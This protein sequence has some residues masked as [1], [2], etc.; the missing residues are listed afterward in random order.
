MAFTTVT[1]SNGVTSLVGTTGVDTA[2]LVTLESNTFVGANT[3]D[4]SITVTLGTGASRVSDY[5]VRLG[6]GD[7]T[8]GFGAATTVLNSFI[9]LDGETLANDGNDTYTGNGLI[10]NS[11]IVGRGGNDTFTGLQLSGSAVNGNTGDD[12]I[13]VGASSTSSVYGGQGLDVINVT[14]N[15]A[16]MMIN[17]NKGRDQISL[18]AVGAAITF[19][20][21]VYG[22]NGNDTITSTNV[23]VAAATSTGVFFSGDLGDDNITGTGGVD[24]INGGDGAD[25]LGGGAGADTISGGAGDDTITAGA[26]ADTVSGGAGND[27]FAIGATDSILAA[28]ASTGFD[29]ITDFSANTAAAGAAVNGDTLDLAALGGGGYALGGANGSIYT[30][31]AANLDADLTAAEA[32]G[33]LGALANA[34]D[35]SAVIIRGS[36]WAGN[37]I[38]QGDAT[39]G[40]DAG[41]TVIKVSSLNGVQAGTF[42]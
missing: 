21:S 42:V 40:Y 3:G 13:T 9:S 19:T 24:T 5:T 38:V 39:A 32:A 30:S 2:T 8:F 16:A 14:G 33:F 26:G 4:D 27:V 41:D 29:E 10:I 6:G 18:G 11:E 23:T 37:Y 36:A 7:D 25:I 34:G 28:N 22:G 31:T 1:G 15:S 20:G 12:N 35:I 17:G